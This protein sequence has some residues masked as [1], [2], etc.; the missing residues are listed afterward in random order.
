MWGIQKFVLYSSFLHS[1]ILGA[2]GLRQFSFE[3]TKTYYAVDFYGEAP[4]SGGAA[5]TATLT[6]PAPAQQTPAKAE[7]KADPKEDILLKSKIK[8]K[9]AKKTASEAKAIP[10]PIPKAP[11]ESAGK[12][13]ASSVI[14]AGIPGSSDGSG[15]GV[16]F[17]KDGWSGSGGTGNFP[18][19]WYVHALKKK[20]DQNWN[21]T[22]GFSKRIYVQVAFL[23]DRNGSM[24]VRDVI[25]SSGDD[26]FDR[27]ALRAVDAS[28]PFPPLPKDYKEPTLRVHIRFTVKH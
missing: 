9:K 10:I 4:A 28:A 26:L 18:Y 14:P 6:A 24:I 25:K 3:E 19:Q 17:G 16:G 15:I 23:I 5:M 11:K 27:Q 22:G 1:C 21:V 13:E 20:L 8:K 7:V 12:S 2:L